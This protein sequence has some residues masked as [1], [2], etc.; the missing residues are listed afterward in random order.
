MISNNEKPA[1]ISLAELSQYLGVHKASIKRWLKRGEIPGFKLGG[2]WRFD[3][4]RIDQWMIEK[5][6][7]YKKREEVSGDGG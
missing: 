7:I 1:L 5:E 6:S 4:Q 2:C 3:R